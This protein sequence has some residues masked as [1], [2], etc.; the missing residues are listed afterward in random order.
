[1]A[2]AQ[3]RWGS[4]P[5]LIG[6]RHVY[7]VRRL[8]RWL[9]AAVPSGHV[10]DAGCGAG[11]LTGILARDGYQVT[12]ID[13]SHEFVAHVRARMAAAGL[14]DRV[15]VRQ[16]DLQHPDLPDARFDGAVCGE[17]L[18]HLPDDAAAVRAIVRALKPGGVLVL[19]VPAGAD[20]YDWLDEWAGHER[21]YDEAA[22]R[23]LLGG[24]G[25]QIE[26]LVRWGFPF[27]AL[28]ERHVQRPGLARAGR[29]GSQGGLIARLA[30]SR[31]VTLGLGAL[32]RVDELFD[33]SQS[34]TGFLAR[35]RKPPA[36]PYRTTAQAQATTDCPSPPQATT[37]CPS[38]T[39]V[40]EAR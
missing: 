30:R 22:L 3:M 11:T 33:G 26:A 15:E 4:A 36:V 1:M 40:G 29:P 39:A 23:K 28:Y 2:T 5:E 16:S 25:L 7:R 20:R 35:A 37:D 32:F 19:S 6:P 17:V 24:A 38:P 21:R 27:M 12:A 10:L 34:G 8:A 18:E 14:A 9:Q 31:A 13:G